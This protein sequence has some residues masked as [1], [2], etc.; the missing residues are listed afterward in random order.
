MPSC[1]HLQ[2]LRV[3]SPDCA[4][5]YCP[6]KVSLSVCMRV[7]MWMWMWMRVCACRSVCLCAWIDVCMYLSVTSCMF[8][9]CVGVFNFYERGYSCLMY[10]NLFI[11]YLNVS[12]SVSVCL[13]ATSWLC[14]QSIAS[15]RT[16]TTPCRIY[17]TLH[18][19]YLIYPYLCACKIHRNEAESAT[20]RL[21]MPLSCEQ[22]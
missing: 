8:C 6:T 14:H 1:C 5:R 13:C 19:S 12:V 21:R 20:A 7:W 16:L 18:R 4:R 3:S 9:R 22:R 10:V 2:P 11:C 15:P 17:T